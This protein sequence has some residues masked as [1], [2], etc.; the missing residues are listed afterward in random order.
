[1][2]IARTVS[3]PA[4]IMKTALAL[5][6]GIGVCTGVDRPARAQSVVPTYDT[7]D[8]GSASGGTFPR[9]FVPSVR[10]LRPY[11]VNATLLADLEDV[12]A[13]LP[14]GWTPIPN[15][16]DPAGSARISINA[17]VGRREVGTDGVVRSSAILAIFT[18]ARNPEGAVERV[19]MGVWQDNADAAAVQNAAAGPGSVRVPDSYDWEVSQKKGTQRFR[20]HV[21]DRSSGLDF[22]I[23]VTAPDAAGTLTTSDLNPP[24]VFRYTDG[25]TA[26]NRQFFAIRYYRLPVNDGVPDV[27]TGAPGLGAAGLGLP[28]GPVRIYSVIPGGAEYRVLAD[29]ATHIVP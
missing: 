9:N 23:E 16:A 20:A 10:Q 8:P 27:R 5:A 7:P 29:T 17:N 11:Q 28:G 12:Q 2:R 13:A 19:L 6:V 22:A 21:K 15:P 3:R 4:G 18:T 14:P 24:L 26:N 25:R 1:M